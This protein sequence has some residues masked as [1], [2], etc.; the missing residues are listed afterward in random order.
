MFYAFILFQSR[1]MLKGAFTEIVGSMQKGCQKGLPAKETLGGKAS[2]RFGW[3]NKC[4]P[5]KAIKRTFFPKNF[6]GK[7]VKDLRHF[8][9]QMY[10]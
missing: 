1:A 9:R 7:K 6:V 2:H 8:L 5:K 3:K 10:G 4:R